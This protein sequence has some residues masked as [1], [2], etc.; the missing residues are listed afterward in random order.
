MPESYVKISHYVMGAGILPTTIH[1]DKLYFLFGKENKYADTPG[2]SDIGGGKDNHETYLETA[3]REGMEEST[4]FFGMEKDIKKLLSRHGTYNIDFQ[5]DTSSYRVHIFP[6]KYDPMLPM[7]YNNNHRFL[8]RKLSSHMIKQSKIFE[9]DELKWIS[10][11]QI[12]RMR[13]KFRCYYGPIIDE[14]LDNRHDIKRFIRKGLTAEKTRKA[15]KPVKKRRSA[16][17]KTRKSG[18]SRKS[19]TRRTKK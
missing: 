5:G 16:A 18:R 17:K 1:E 8:E 13:S 6:M 10:I 3:Y 15:G 2:W 12:P 9:K 14:I 4:G 7:Y 19:K 11:D